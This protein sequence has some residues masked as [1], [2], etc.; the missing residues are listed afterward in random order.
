MSAPSISAAAAAWTNDFRYS[1]TYFLV[2]LH[3][4]AFRTKVCS[5]TCFAETQL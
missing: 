1:T 4:A 2:F 5:L 3:F